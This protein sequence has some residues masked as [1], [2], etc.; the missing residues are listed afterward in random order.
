LFPVLAEY[1]EFLLAEGKNKELS[2][3]F[4]TAVVKDNVFEGE[5]WL[6]ELLDGISDSHTMGHLDGAFCTARKWHAQVKCEIGRTGRYRGIAL[7]SIFSAPGRAY[8]F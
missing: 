5:R 7:Q 2:E 6:L 3:I 4:R 8:L 1:P